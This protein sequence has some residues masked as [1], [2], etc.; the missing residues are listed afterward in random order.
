MWIV[1]KCRYV[2]FFF[3]ESL[4]RQEKFY[5]FTHSEM[6]I[7]S[8]VKRPSW[9]KKSEKINT[10]K[11]QIK[12]FRFLV[13]CLNAHHSKYFLHFLANPQPI[14]PSLPSPPKKKSSTRPIIKRPTRAVVIGVYNPRTQEADRSIVHTAR[15]LL[16]RISIMPRAG[17]S[18]SRPRYRN[19]SDV[20]SRCGRAMIHDVRGFFQLGMCVMIQRRFFVEKSRMVVVCDIVSGIHPWSFLLENYCS[21]ERQIILKNGILLLN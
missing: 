11:F 19:E 4:E 15:E 3:A 17:I 2:S 1:G 7:L 18:R 6:T 5:R 10:F 12:F 8:I 16:G 14:V 20:V 21:L 9:F 13:I